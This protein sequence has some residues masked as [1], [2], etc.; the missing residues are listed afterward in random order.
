MNYLLYGTEQ[1][2][3]EKEL[4]KII[5][6]YKVGEIS[7]TK[8]DLSIDSLKNILDD[9]MTISLF[10]E[11]KLIVVN[12]ANIFNRGKTDDFIDLLVKYLSDP[13]PNTILVFI[14]PN[15]TV[16][17]TKKIT[18]LIKEKG[19]IKELNTINPADLIKN[20]CENYKIDRESINLLISRIGNNMA[21]IE[22]ELQKLMLYKIDDKVITKEDVI[23]LTSVNI[24]TDIFKFIDHIINKEKDLAMKIYSEMIKQGEEPI[25]IIALLASKFRLMYQ[26]VELTKSGCS[27]QDIAS[28]LGVHIYPVKLAIQ[29]GM[30]YNM[31]L[32]LD[33]LNKLS[34]L[35]INIKTGQIE[36]ILGLEL[37]IL[38]V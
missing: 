31:K 3:I 32:V 35:D 16:D 15:S 37:F 4:D 12:N 9:S 11:N 20:I 30:K 36:P 8:Y 26:A 34:D 22:S 19:I 24:D 33:Y 23:N 7:V 18:K 25:K 10:D 1:F 21:L 6:K 27:Q 28:T 29:A 2:L 5:N 13:N 14:N 38:D 17:A